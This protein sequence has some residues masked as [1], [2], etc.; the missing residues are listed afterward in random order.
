MTLSSH[1]NKR[2]N[3]D[4]GKERVGWNFFGTCSWVV[5]WLNCSTVALTKDRWSN[6]TGGKGFRT[7]RRAAIECVSWPSARHG[8]T[9][10]V[11]DYLLRVSPCAPPTPHSVTSPLRN[12]FL[13]R[14]SVH[15]HALPLKCLRL[16]IPPVFFDGQIRGTRG[17]SHKDGRQ[18]ASRGR[19]RIRS[20]FSPRLK[21]DLF[22]FGLRYTG[23][24]KGLHC[25]IP[26][27]TDLTS[28]S[29]FRVVFGKVFRFHLG[30]RCIL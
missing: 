25:R 17:R 24:P 29:I 27:R 22:L 18:A 6:L 15:L 28:F 3:F 23:S 11:N 26:R 8:L 5:P 9:I 19:T 7:G 14:R 1:V 30:T 21:L 12:L 16:P 2:S 4:S 10:T 13:V 20:F